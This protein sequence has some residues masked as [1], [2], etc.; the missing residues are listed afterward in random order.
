MK[1]QTSYE[2]FLNTNLITRYLHG[3]K[4]KLLFL[5]LDSLYE[6]EILTQ[7]RT[8]TFLDIGCGPAHIYGEL[9]TRYQNIKYIGKRFCYK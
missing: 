8:T 3:N 5:H 2:N 6:K 4:S 7:E 1:I 9:S